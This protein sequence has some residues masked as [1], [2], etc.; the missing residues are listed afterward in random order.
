MQTI[1]F[2]VFFF[3]LPS[4]CVHTLQGTM[5]NLPSRFMIGST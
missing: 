4:I 5:Y 1:Q 2:K 3:S